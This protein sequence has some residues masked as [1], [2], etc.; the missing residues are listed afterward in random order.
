MPEFYALQCFSCEQYQVCQSRKDSKFVCK[1]CGARQSMRRIHA[2]ADTAR[3][4]REH[5]QRLNLTR[6]LAGEMYEDENMREHPDVDDTWES[7]RLSKHAESSR[8]GQRSDQRSRW[9]SYVTKTGHEL[10]T[11]PAEAFLATDALHQ[12]E[13]NVEFIT[14]LPDAMIIQRGRSK[15]KQG[16]QLLACESKKQGEKRSKPDNLQFGYRRRGGNK[17]NDHESTANLHGSL[18]PIESHV[19]TSKQTVGTR[20]HVLICEEAG[21]DDITLVAPGREEVFEDDVCF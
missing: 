2:R 10:S 15:R 9:D 20:R 18:E 12:N 6:G 11:S 1:L 7:T 3:P 16:N 8:G 17:E 21:A 5:V 14:A 4:V 13:A 19:S